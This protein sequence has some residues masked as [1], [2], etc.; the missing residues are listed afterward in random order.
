MEYGPA[1]LN[2]FS[3]STDPLNKKKKLYLKKRDGAY[4]N[5]SNLLNKYG[6][7]ENN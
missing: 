6:I 5:P 3:V 4:L 2:T 7:Y 1:L